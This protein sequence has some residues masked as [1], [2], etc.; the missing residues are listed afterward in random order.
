VVANCVPVAVD[1]EALLRRVVAEVFDADVDVAY[2]TEP[3]PPHVHRARLTDPSGTRHAGL[4]ASYEWFDAT[5]YDLGVST[6]LFDY[7]DEEQYKEAVLRA[8][9]RV[10]RAYLRGEGRIEHKRVLIR[11]HPVLRIEVDNREW[12]LGRRL[13]RP[14][15]PD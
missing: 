5:I 6:R 12:E 9:A 7:D 14:H 8:L 2:S 3:K 15:Y 11:S 4:R 13:S 10:V 1:V